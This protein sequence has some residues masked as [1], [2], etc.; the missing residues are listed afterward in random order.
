M[1][2]FS[3]QCSLPWGSAHTEFPPGLKPFSGGQEESAGGMITGERQDLGDSA[4][5]SALWSMGGRVLLRSLSDRRPAVSPGSS[6]ILPIGGAR[7]RLE[8]VDG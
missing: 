1:T 4:R 6:W 8:K 7:G 2:E 5:G 3:V